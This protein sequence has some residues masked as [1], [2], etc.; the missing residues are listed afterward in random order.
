MG[1]IEVTHKVCSLGNDIVIAMRQRFAQRLYAGIR[2]LLAKRIKGAELL[3]ETALASH[4]V[5]CNAGDRCVIHSQTSA[6]AACAFRP[7][8]SS[9]MLPVEYV[10]GRFVLSLGGFC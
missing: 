3:F 8:A 1:Q 2:G 5:Q 7:V 4:R 9:R 10:V 6:D